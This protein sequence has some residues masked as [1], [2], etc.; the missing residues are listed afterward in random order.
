LSRTFPLLVFEPP[1]RHSARRKQKDSTRLLW[2]I[3]SRRFSS[4]SFSRYL[5]SNPDNRHNP[6]LGSRH[7]HIGIGPPRRACSFEFS[8][9]LH[10]F[11]MST[12][13][14][15]AL[16]FCDS[17]SSPDLDAYLDSLSPLSQLPSP[18]MKEAWWREETLHRRHDSLTSD[19]SASGKSVSNTSHHCCKA[20]SNHCK[21]RSRSS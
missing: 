15:P 20:P 4:F 9:H 5:N 18:T 13:S 10:S 11:V 1:V 19:I 21:Q 6:G 8:T 14:S 2:C 17:L 7:I 12:L 3:I 16:S